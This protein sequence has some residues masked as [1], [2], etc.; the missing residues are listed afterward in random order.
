MA[1]DKKFFV[2]RRLLVQFFLLAVEFNMNDSRCDLLHHVSD[3]VVLVTKTV[4]V[5]LT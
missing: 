1:P 3:E 5:L 4:W 2:N